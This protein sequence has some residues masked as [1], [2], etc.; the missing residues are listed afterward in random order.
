MFRPSRGPHAVRARVFE[1]AGL[2]RRL[3]KLDILKV[4]VI[5]EILNWK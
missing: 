2:E 1:T 5:D 3:Q 4:N